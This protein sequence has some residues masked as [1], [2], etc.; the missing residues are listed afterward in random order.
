MAYIIG[1]VRGLVSLIAAFAAAF[2]QAQDKPGAAAPPSFEVAT[3]KPAA[4]DARGTYIRPGPG[5][6]VSLTNMGLR[7]M[8]VFA[9]DIQPFQLSGGP[10]WMDSAHF[11][12]V[13]KPEATTG[14]FD[15]ALI[16]PMLQRLLADRFELRVHKETKEM[17]IYALVMARK[18]GKPGP[19]LTESKEGDCVKPDPTR[20]P[21]PPP[22]GVAPPRYCGGL[23]MSVNRITGVA[24]PVSSLAPLL[25]R[26]L[27]RT[28]VDETGLKGNFDIELEWT[29]DE[30]QTFQRP[31]GAANPAPADPTAPS[32]FT[33][34]QERLGIKI[35]SKKGPVEMIVVDQAEKP[36]EN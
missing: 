7:E 20:P 23:M 30:T 33:A 18:D 34:V 15:I 5:G 28:V 35:E 32:L 8:I 4:P 21:A 13:A 2:A 10:S 12:I 31:G 24:N 19:G 22:P 25:S 3:I 1:A 16:R 11:D 17:P 27:G 26:T 6:G 9:W 14:R 36:S 29:P